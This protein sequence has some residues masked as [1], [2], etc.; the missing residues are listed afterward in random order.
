MQRERRVEAVID[1]VCVGGGKTSIGRG[2]IIFI[3]T[4]GG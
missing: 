3:D 2:L 1:S 4:C